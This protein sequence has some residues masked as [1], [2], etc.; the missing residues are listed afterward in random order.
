MIEWGAEFDRVGD[1]L[2]L[3]REGGHS[4]A[5]IAHAFGD[6]TGREIMRVVI[7]RL[8]AASNV[9]VW[10]RTFAID[11]VSDG[12]ECCGALIWHPDSGLVQVWAKQ[13]ILATGGA[14]QLYR[15]TTNPAV[16]TADGLAMAYRAGVQLRDLEFMQFHPTVLYI[17]GSA[18][19]LITEAVRGEGGYLR[20][21]TGQRFMPE[22]DPRA[23]LAPRDIVARA[24]AQRMRQL[25]QSHVYLD[26]THLE[27]G[28]VRSRFPGVDAMCC[29]FGLDITRDLIP[30][31]PAA[32][33]MIGG[34]SVDEQGR[35]G[36]ERLWAC[37][38]CTASGLHGANRLG[39]NSLLEALV[40]GV[41]CG[42]GAAAAAEA[43][44]ERF[45]A[46]PVSN[47]ICR[48]AEQDY[49]LTDLRNSL[50][51]LMWRNAGIE[52]CEEELAE[53]ARTIDFWCQYALLNQF[54]TP[55]GWELQNMLTVAGLIVLAARERAE[56]RGVHFRRDFPETEAEHWARHI[57]LR[58]PAETESH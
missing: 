57:T 38:E 8:R 34:V 40:F 18:R 56:S 37:G 28:L 7:E 54:E 11:L 29:R 44:P 17:A 20:D 13:T 50:T 58:R 14:G 24:I 23:E 10:E 53:A 51:S 25:H 16:A 9:R 6:A 45:Q 19:H 35:T 46:L 52:R 12:N 49:N 41:R 33:Y 22:V 48:S 4:H 27:P 39:S 32:H 31:R 3:T 26:L 5:R 47:P 55:V 15:E 2:A 42:A 21:K 43:M 36:M 30:V 1:R